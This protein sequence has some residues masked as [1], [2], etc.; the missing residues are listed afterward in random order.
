MK[1]RILIAAVAIFAVAFPAGTSSAAGGN[2]A[3]VGTYSSNYAQQGMRDDVA[4]LYTQGNQPY[5]FVAQF[6]GDLASCDEQ[7][8]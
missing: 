5:S 1:P 7:V 6:H 2:A 4:H 8:H 3:C